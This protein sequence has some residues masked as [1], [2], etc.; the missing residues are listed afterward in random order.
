MPGNR[1]DDARRGAGEEEG[2][3]K[4]GTCG[5]G[6]R[7]GEQG[8]DAEEVGGRSVRVVGEGGA[9][10]DE[11][12]RVDKEGED[13]QREGEFGDGVGEAGA[14]GGEGGAVGDFLGGLVGVVVGGGVGGYVAC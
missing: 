13:A 4:D 7:G 6:E 11:D 9:R 8:V 3:R 10:H 1:A 14:D 2:E 12:G 5:G